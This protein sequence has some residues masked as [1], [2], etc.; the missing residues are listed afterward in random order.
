MSNEGRKDDGQKLR[1]DLI[2]P[3]VDEAL[4]TVLMDGAAKYG[5]NNWMNGIKYRRIYAALQRHL[6]AWR[7]G[8]IM[9]QDSGRPH[10]WHALTELSFLTYYEDNLDLYSSF[11]D[12]I[13]E[14][15]GEEVGS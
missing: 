2:P 1:Y 12:F 8:E 5:D 7:R 11:N 6:A 9:D 10:L 13:H 15:M 4:A 3:I 14:W